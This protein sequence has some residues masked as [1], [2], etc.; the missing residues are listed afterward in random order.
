VTLDQTNRAVVH[1][2]AVI[3]GIKL[4]AAVGVEQHAGGKR[5]AAR[6][7]INVVHGNPFPVYGGGPRASGL[8]N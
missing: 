2:E 3:Q 4:L 6:Q 7:E 8:K 1:E 5:L